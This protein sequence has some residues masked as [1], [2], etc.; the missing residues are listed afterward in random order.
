[1]ATT[2]TTTVT[3][4]Y[5][6][7]QPDP[8]YVVNV[9][10]QVTGTDGEHTASIDGNIQCAVT[11]DKPSFIPYNELTEAD[12]IAWLDVVVDPTHMQEQIQKNIA[13]Q[14]DPQHEDAPLPWTTTTS[15]TTYIPPT[16]PDPT[17]TTS[18]TLPPMPPDPPVVD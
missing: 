1:M 6:V 12:V 11:E 2:Y 16:P 13:N 18:T 15:T 7:Q 8:N 14:I 4:L 10:F 3:N 17:T 5:T 9:L